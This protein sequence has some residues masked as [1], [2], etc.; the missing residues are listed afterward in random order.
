MNISGATNVALQLLNIST[1]DAAIYD[2]ILSD[3][4]GTIGC[5]VASLTVVNAPQFL[6]P[7]L[8]TNG[9][10]VL[11][12]LTAQGRSNQLQYSTDLTRLSQF[13]RF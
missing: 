6:T 2:A 3:S 8:T 13:H 1:N 9:Q 7:V 11:S 5:A 12:W 10:L 4:N